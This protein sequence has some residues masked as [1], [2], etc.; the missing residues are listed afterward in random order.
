ML[1]LQV[2]GPNTIYTTKKFSR[3]IYIALQ[4][5]IGRRYAPTSGTALN[6]CITLSRAVIGIW[7]AD[8]EGLRYFLLWLI[9]DIIG[10]LLAT[11]FYNEILEPCIVYA[12]IKK[13]EALQRDLKE[14]EMKEL[15]RKISYVGQF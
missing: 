2:V 5:Y 12:R 7:Y 3:Y 8:W 1:V 6:A 14:V 13:F 4:V 15:H 11:F 10:C 9:G